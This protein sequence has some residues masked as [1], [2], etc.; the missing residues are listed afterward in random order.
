MTECI[1]YKKII[2]FLISDLSDQRVK[3]VTR[4]TKLMSED[5]TL[6]PTPSFVRV[7]L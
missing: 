7:S 4:S 6:K 2:I 5:N 1:K 3:V